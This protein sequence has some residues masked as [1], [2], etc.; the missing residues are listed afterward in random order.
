MRTYLKV[1]LE[2]YS[3]CTVEHLDIVSQAG[4]VCTIECNQV[5]ISQ[6]T[7]ERV[8]KCIWQFDFTFAECSMTYSIKRI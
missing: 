7:W 3:E 6:Y 1:N 8:K 5:S 2:A 4:W